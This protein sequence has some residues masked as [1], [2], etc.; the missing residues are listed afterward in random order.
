MISTADSRAAQR[1]ASRTNPGL[2][3]AVAMLAAGPAAANTERAELLELK[4][5]IVN[6]VDALVAQK[7]LSA[8]Q[9][10]ALKREAAAKAKVQAAQE[11]PAV[12]TEPLPQDA[13]GKKVVRVPYVPQ[14]VKDEIRRDVK[15]ELRQEVA[16]DVAARAKEEKW[17]TKDALPDWVNRFELS[18]DFRLRYQFDSF[19]DENQPFSY[20]NFRAI[21]RAGSVSGPDTF[22]NFTEDRNRL[23]FRFRYGFM[24]QVTDD[25][26]AS[27][28]F[29]TG[30]LENP[31]TM[32]QTA[33]NDFNRWTVGI[34]R[35]YLRWRDLTESNYEWISA[36]IGRFQA[37]FFVPTEMVFD[38]DLQFEGLAATGSYRFDLDGGEAGGLTRDT[39]V[40]LTLGGFPMLESE[41]AFDDDSSNDKWLLGGQLGLDH[42]F[43]GPWQTKAALALYD[44]VNVVGR[45]NPNGPVGSTLLDWTA[46]GQLV[47]G[48]TMYPIRFDANGDPTLFGLASDFTIA[49][50]SAELRYTHFSPV[51]VWLTADLAKNIGYDG[52]DI[53]KRIGA[54]VDE[55][56]NA[57]TLQ[58][59]VGYPEIKRLGEW[60]LGAYYRYLQRDAVLD[61]FTDSNFHL[62][63]TDAKG[64]VL[65]GEYGIANRTWLRLRYYSVDEID[66]APL[67]IDNLHLELSTKF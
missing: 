2:A 66:L 26:Y 29:A 36:Q 48:N 45:F 54:P 39:G 15:A 6:L 5:T 64:F 44:Y 46:P 56:T 8:E 67:G 59:D 40:W 47:K 35:A 4:N 25:L 19:D 10:A 28:R 13:P 23:R 27:A 41:L 57:Y 1:R 42:S 20:P 30:D 62:G 7:V 21:N 60:H 53:A 61:G 33:G 11:A 52:S 24:A 18:G 31:V 22:F 43:R 58:F 38:N 12:E 51:H 65:V 14:F 63:G 50:L 9:A 55:R 49:N 32:Q 34:D 16:Q 37:P 3:L 17:G